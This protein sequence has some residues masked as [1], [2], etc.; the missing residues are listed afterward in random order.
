MA[1]DSLA[2]I[3]MPDNNPNDGT[4][5][6]IEKYIGGT[7]GTEV[8]LYIVEEGGHTWPDSKNP[9]YEVATGKICHDFDASEVIWQFF[10]EHPRKQ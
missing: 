7:N 4:R 9:Q 10:K 5:V 8:F 2:L 6:K 1:S 3:Q